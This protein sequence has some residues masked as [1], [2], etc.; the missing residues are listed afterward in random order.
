MI[1]TLNLLS[2]ERQQLLRRS[3]LT[4]A[5][6]TSALLL[7][8]MEVAIMAILQ[9][10]NAILATEA[11]RR[12]DESAQLTSTLERAQ[13]ETRSGLTLTDEEL[14]T[15]RKAQTSFIPWS[16][17]LIQLF[18]VNPD[19]IRLQTLSI[20]ADRNGL[21]LKGVAD[22]RESLIRYRDS[23]LAFPLITNLDAPIS[24]LT[25]RER[26]PFELTGIFNT[27]PLLP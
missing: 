6:A 4:R 3:R 8:L 24:S 19:G 21:T 20:D 14:Q 2:K 18:S 9:T 22:R 25:Q 11:K 27:E 23:L 7:F 26:I 13:G 10:G 16:D 1:I 5:L 12:T 15:I 17:V